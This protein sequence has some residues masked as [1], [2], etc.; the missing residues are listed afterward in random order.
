MVGR[1]PRLCDFWSWMRCLVLRKTSSLSQ[2]GIWGPVSFIYVLFLWLMVL[3]SSGHWRL[4]CLILRLW[5]DH[6]LGLPLT[7]FFSGL[8]EHLMQG[9]RQDLTKHVHP[10]F[11][12]RM[13][14]IPLSSLSSRSFVWEEVCLLSLLTLQMDCHWLAACSRRV[15]ALHRS[16]IYKNIPIKY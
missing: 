1:W 4:L 10:S 11:F 12:P 14:A 6:G 8:A 16:F 2:W 9:D 13:L 15:L 7:P 5:R 3:P